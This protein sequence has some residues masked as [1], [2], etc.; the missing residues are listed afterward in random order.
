MQLESVEYHTEYYTEYSIRVFY[1]Y[2]VFIPSVH[3]ECS[4]S[5]IIGVCLLYKVSIHD[6]SALSP[7]PMIG[8][9]IHSPF[10]ITNHESPANTLDPCTAASPRVLLDPDQS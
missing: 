3:T 1:P 6:D 2:R 9:M 4:Y 7:S 8:I 10:T 5:N